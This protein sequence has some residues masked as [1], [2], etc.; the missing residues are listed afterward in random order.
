[1]RRVLPASEFG[2]WFSV[3][4]PELAHGRPAT[5]FRPAT[6]TDHS[7]SKIAHLD[8]LNLS[9]AWCLR[10]L[11]QSLAANDSRRERMLHAS[12]LHLVQGLQHVRGNYIGEH[13]LATFATLALEG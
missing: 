7:D 2:E 13:W 4:L 8:G 9:R 3:F 5:L 11:A 10:S 6:V 1:M 12:E